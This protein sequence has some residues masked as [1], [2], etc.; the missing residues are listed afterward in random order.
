MARGVLAE[1]R[2]S[3]KPRSAIVAETALRRLGGSR[4]DD[5]VDQLL[6]GDRLLQRLGHHG[7]VLHAEFLKVG[8]GDDR[9]L[10][11]VA[12]DDLLVGVLHELAGD[13][14]AALGLGDVDVVR[15]A[16]H[17]ARVE[18]VRE[19]RVE[20]L[21]ADAGQVGAEVAALAVDRVALAQVLV[22]TC[23]PATGLPGGRLVTSF[24]ICSTT[25]TRS[26]RARS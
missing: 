6:L 20:V 1:R 22:K 2:G 9:L 7:H 19:D 12:K 8:L 15:R 23:W 24:F 25:F 16:D 4:E 17:E 21:A 18:E 10:G 13:R 14:V 26:G 11:L 5:E 3:A